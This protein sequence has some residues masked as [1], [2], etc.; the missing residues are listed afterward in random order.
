MDTHIR[1]ST[2]KVTGAAFVLLAQR[3]LQTCIVPGDAAHIA[4]NRST[5][6]RVISANGSTERPDPSPDVSGSSP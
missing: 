5:A 4:R 3:M 2:L 6:V 1:I